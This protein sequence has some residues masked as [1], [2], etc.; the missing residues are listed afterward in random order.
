MN[1][2]TIF[3]LGFHNGD[4]TGF[5]LSRGY[6][7]IS[8]EANPDLVRK[9][10]ERFKSQ[11]ENESLI[12]INAAVTE[13]VGKV[14]FYINTSRTEWSSCYLHMAESDGSISE[15]VSVDS[16]TLPHLIQI[17]GVPYYMKVDIEGFDLAVA[18]QLGISECKPRYVSF[19]TSKRDYAGIFSYL[20]V[21]GYDAFQLINQSQHNLRSKPENLVEGRDVD[22]QFSEFS[23]GYFGRDLPEEK[24]LTLDD[25]LTRYV[26]YKELKKWDNVELGVGWLDVHAVHDHNNSLRRGD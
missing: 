3:D 6:R 10:E 4:D 7:V 24:W 19:E 18:R 21:A 13:N 5:Y 12:L 20:Y 2:K 15:K 16:V 9:G 1:R 23:S 8:V 14:E 25:A 26:Y 11:I 17:Y 22:Y